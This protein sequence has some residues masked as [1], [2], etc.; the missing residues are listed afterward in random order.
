[1]VK[2]GESVRI[3]DGIH[4]IYGRSGGRFPFCNVLIVEKCLIDAGAGIEI[5]RAIAEKV[6]CLILSHTHP[7]HASGAWIFNSLGKKVYMPMDV[8]TSL[9]SLALRFVT[10]RFADV[11]KTFV[12][13]FGMRDFTAEVLDPSL[14]L[15]VEAIPLPGH[16]LDHHV[17]LID[18]VLYAA[19]VDLT[20]FGPFYG[21]PES[22]PWE[23][24]KGI[25][26][27]LSLDVRVL[28]P[29]HSPPVFGDEI[30]SRL[31]E[32]LEFFD[33]R[34]EAILEILSEPRRIEEIVERSPIYGRKPYAKEMLD[35]FERNMIEK[36][37]KKLVDAKAVE[38]VGKKYVRRV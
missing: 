30:E 20:T 17:F 24:K 21:N 37:L 7:D 19:D 5:I 27:L 26:R 23:F 2:A 33:R 38:I 36:H 10:E 28:I 8:P 22:D 14:N 13:S 25:E 9:D 32:Y 12:R 4:L 1:M 3:R 31:N 34:D 15:P 16:C 29:S 35:F 6:D 18:D 11:W